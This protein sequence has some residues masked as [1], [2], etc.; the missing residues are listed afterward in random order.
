MARW[1][2][3]CLSRPTVIRGRYGQLGVSREDLPE[4]VIQR[5]DR[6]VCRQQAR[7]HVSYP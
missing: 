5:L 1:A 2:A 7:A 3:A 6:A 4:Q